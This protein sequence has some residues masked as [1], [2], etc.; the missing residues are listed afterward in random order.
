MI[1]V[2]HPPALILAQ[3]LIDLGLLTRHDSEKDW[4]VFVDQM[5]DAPDELAS[6]R[7]TPGI[8]DGR[9]MEDG[10]YVE[11]PGFQL[12][13]RVRADQYLR[14]WQKANALHNAL[15]AL[16][17]ETVVLGKEF[18]EASHEIVSVT[19]SGPVLPIGQDPDTQRRH[20]FTINGRITLNLA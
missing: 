9:L 7:D 5:P 17:R 3:A 12:R 2:T 10:R 14:G 16:R 1:N 4:P 15:A 8:L 18:D 20:N 11:H 13:V 6:L 19:L